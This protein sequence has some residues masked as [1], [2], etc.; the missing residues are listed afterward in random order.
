MSNRMYLCIDLKSFYASVEC[1]ERGLDPFTTNLVVADPTRERGTICLA[2]TPAMKALGIHNR[3][4][5]FEIPTAVDYIMAP[6]RMKL[7]IQYAADIYSIYLKYI[8]KDDIQVY[9]ID[10]AFLDVTDY[11]KLYGLD[12]Y[13]LGVRIISDILATTGITAACGIG[14]NL[15]L[16]KVALDITAKHSSDHIGYL[17]EDLYCKTLWNHRPITDFWRVGHGIS[18]RLYNMGITTMGEVA[19]ADERLLY[20]TFG[21]DAEYLIDH[22]WGREPVTIPQIKAYK[23]QHNSLSSGQI[24]FRDYTYDEGLLIVKEMVDLLCLELTDRHL[25]T[26]NIGLYVGYSKDA[27][28]SSRGS[29]CMSTTTCSVTIITRYYCELYR[30]IVN[31]LAPIRRIIIDFNNIMDEAYE[32]YDLFTDPTELERSRRIQNAVIDI[33]RRYGKNSILKGMNFLE[34]ATTIER[35]MQ[36]GGHKSG[37][38]N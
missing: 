32:Q 36:I 11:L 1:V 13:G 26:S 34:G 17:D 5:V 6:P 19:H 35:N 23:A 12:A 8:S 4:R 9:S 15:Y 3:C 21:I 33:K 29:T 10:E 18:K 22:A 38:T 24:L 37:E 14:T 7:Y 25:V 28:P 20:R 31:P 2:I 16:A 27:F 30:K